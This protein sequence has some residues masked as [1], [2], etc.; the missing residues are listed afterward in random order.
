VAVSIREVASR[1]GVSHGTVSKVLNDSAG[2]QIAAG[3][4]DRVRRAA[5][6]LGYLPNAAARALVRRQL[7]AIGVVLPPGE[8]SPLST[9]FFATAFDALVRAAADRGQTTAVLPGK[10][11]AGAGPN[12]AA[13]FNGR[14]DGLVLFL[15]STAPR[16]PAPPGPISS[17]PSRRLASPS[18]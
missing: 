9:P 4:R 5:Q 16:P 1:A 12:L 15:Q 14:C 2:A 18:F 13:F 10:I 3:T 11:W 6:E 17:R 8:V 7:D